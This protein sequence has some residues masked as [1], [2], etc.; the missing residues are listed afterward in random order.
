MQSSSGI[1]KRVHM[2]S[3]PHEE[4]S[5]RP[6]LHTT[7]GTSLVALHNSNTTIISTWSSRAAASYG[8]HD[9]AQNTVDPR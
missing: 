9:R 7:D 8:R 3:S 6:N 1:L 4:S 5:G 2:S